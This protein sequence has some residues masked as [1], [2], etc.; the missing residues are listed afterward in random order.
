MTRTAAMPE[1]QAS[2]DDVAARALVNAC[3]E[4]C[5]GLRRGVRRLLLTPQ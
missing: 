2:S 4:A 5:A 1:R 3:V